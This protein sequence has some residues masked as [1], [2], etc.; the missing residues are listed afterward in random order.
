[1]SYSCK[2]QKDH[3]VRLGMRNQ[4]RQ[5]VLRERKGIRGFLM[6]AFRKLNTA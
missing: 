3:L 6:T 5:L 4:G 2:E 1:M